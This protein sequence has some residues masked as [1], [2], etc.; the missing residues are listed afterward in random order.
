[1]LVEQEVE[2]C[3]RWCFLEVECLLIL[4]ESGSSFQA[5]EPAFM[6]QSCVGT[7]KFI[8]GGYPAGTRRVPVQ[9]GYEKSHGFSSTAECLALVKAFVF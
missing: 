4:R 5:D 3:L 8:P 1:M 2:T 9:V 7:A 6:N